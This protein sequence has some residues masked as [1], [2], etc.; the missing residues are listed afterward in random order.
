MQS[1][2]RGLVKW[3]GHRDPLEASTVVFTA[4]TQALPDQDTYI[5][6]DSGTP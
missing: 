3:E 2:K 1:A 5:A 6:K 4:P